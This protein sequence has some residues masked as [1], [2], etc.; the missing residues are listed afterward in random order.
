MKFYALW[1]A[2]FWRNLT[3]RCQW[4][5][6]K[7]QRVGYRAHCALFRYLHYRIV[8]AFSRARIFFKL[9]PRDVKLRAAVAE[10][11]RQCLLNDNKTFDYVWLTQRR[12]LLIEAVTYGRNRRL[13]RELADC[14]ARLNGVVEPLQRA[15]QPVLLAPLH[16]VSDVLSTMIGATAYPGKATV[17]TSRSANAHSEAERRLGGLDLN[18]CSIHED[19]K[20]I[21]GN[22][23]T[24]VMAAAENKRNIILFPDITPDFTQFASK[25]KAEK[26]SCRLFERPASLHSGII[27]LARMMSAQVVFYHLYFDKGLKIKIHEPVAP[28]MLKDE[29]PRIIEQSIHDYSTDWML[30]HSHSL[31]FIND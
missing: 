16:M 7:L 9:I 3:V 15:G 1:C 11:N 22:L 5:I 21:A 8:F 4:L 13:L 17:I 6:S 26:L 31:F 14:S 19:N 23:M 20:N 27:R 2:L 24:S 29:M 30:W 18:Y 10:S 12:K 28:R 25:D